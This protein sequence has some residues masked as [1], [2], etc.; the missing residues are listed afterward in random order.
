[1]HKSKLGT[2]VID[3][4][5]TDLNAAANFWGNALGLSQSPERDPKYISLI[6]GAD[7]LDI[8]VQSVDHPSRVHIDI[9]TNDIPAEVKRLELLGAK[10]VSKLDKWCVMIA[11]T[12]QRFCIVPI[13]TDNFEVQANVWD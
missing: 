3:C 11:P 8:E 4:K 12:G 10:M 5:T 6:A 7:G 1:M 9:E 2:I 13:Q